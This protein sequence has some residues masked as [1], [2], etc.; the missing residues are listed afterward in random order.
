MDHCLDA[1]NLCPG[2]LIFDR[3]LLQERLGEGGVG[4]VMAAQDQVLRR[5]VALKC[6]R[7]PRT[8]AR[9]TALRFLREARAMAQLESPHTVRI[10]DALPGVLVME[11]LRGSD[12]ARFLRHRGRVSARQ[13]ALLLLQACDALA[14]AHALGIVHRDIKLENLFLTCRPGHEARGYLKVLDFGLSK[15]FMDP[16]SAQ[17]EVTVTDTQCVLGSPEFMSPEQTRCSR[18]VDARTDIWALGAVLYALLSGRRPFARR[19][20]ADVRYAVLAGEYLPLES[21]CDDLPVGLDSIVQR[22]LQLDRDARYESVKELA[23]AL[24]P[25]AKTP[26]RTGSTPPPQPEIVPFERSRSDTSAQ[27]PRRLEH[28]P[29]SFLQAPGNPKV[30]S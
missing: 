20:V 1:A 24:E 6:L 26:R 7:C 28:G 21:V 23:A 25:F 16:G 22:C 13:A 14:E 19:F 4:I 17:D 9:S 8:D 3:Y 15:V 18:D 12:L 11:Y 2:A 30:S 29:L 27:R 5:R 10:F